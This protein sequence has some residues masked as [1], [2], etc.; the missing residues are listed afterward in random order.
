MRLNKTLLAAAALVSVTAATKAYDVYYSDWNYSQPSFSYGSYGVGN[1]W[2]G[3]E[4][5]TLNA[6]RTY[7][8]P[9]FGTVVNSNETILVN[10]GV[11]RGISG[12]FSWSGNEYDNNGGAPGS[13]AYVFGEL[14][15]GSETTVLGGLVPQ[16]YFDGGEGY[17][18]SGTFNFDSTDTTTNLAIGQV[19]YGIYMDTDGNY[20]GQNVSGGLTVYERNVQVARTGSGF[21]G[22]NAYTAFAFDNSETLSGSY[23][24]GTTFVGRNVL[25]TASAWSDGEGNYGPSLAGSVIR[26]GDI[27]L[28][29]SG[30]EGLYA[31]DGGWLDIRGDLTLGASG[32][33]YI[34]DGEI[35]ANTYTQYYAPGT[36]NTLG[37]LSIETGILSVRQ[38]FAQDMIA[39]WGQ[40]LGFRDGAVND[41]RL[42]LSGLGYGFNGEGFYGPLGSAGGALRSITGENVQ[43]GNISIFGD[44][45]GF[46][47]FVSGAVIGTDLGSKLTING[48]INGLD[49]LGSQGGSTLVFSSEGETVQNGHILSGIDDVIK[50]GQGELLIN[51]SNT[52]TGDLA[53]QEGTVRITNSGAL[54]GANVDPLVSDHTYVSSG[55]ALVL[56]QAAGLSLGD[57]IYITGTGTL[58]TGAALYNKSGSNATTG[59]V[60]VQNGDATVRVDASSSLTVGSVSAGST[61]Y[62]LTLDVRGAD[63]TAGNFTVNSQTYGL[64]NLVK[65][66]TGNATV[67]ELSGALGDIDVNGG[68]L[69]VLGTGSSALNVFDRLDIDGTLDGEGAPLGN[70]ELRGDYHYGEFNVSA[71]NTLIKGNVTHHGAGGY[72]LDISDNAVVTVDT[73]ATLTTEQNGDVDASA[74]IIDKSKLIVKGTFQANGGSIID[75]DDEATVEV[76][77]GGVVNSYIIANDDSNVVIRTGGTIVGNV[78]T[79]DNAQFTI[80]SGATHTGDYNAYGNADIVVNG[81]IGE[82]NALSTNFLLSGSARL[83]GSGRVSGD[84]QQIAGTVAPGNSTNILSVGGNYSIS[85]SGVL[86][87]EIGGTDGPANDPTGNDQLRVTGTVTVSGGALLDF[88]PYNGYLPVRRGVFQILATSAGAARATIGKF[89]TVDTTGLDNGAG[90]E[91]RMLFDHSTGK[92][93]GTG[94]VRGVQTFR[95]YGDSAN[96]RE[97]GR[98]LWMESIA[99][100]G[101]AFDDNYGTG[102]IN[103]SEAL[104]NSGLKTFIL[105]KDASLVD[106]TQ[107]ATDLGAAAVSVLSAV[108]VGAALD[109]LSP[110]AYSGFGEIAVRLNRNIAL[111]GANGRR[112]GDEKNWGFSLGYSG[113]QLTSSS[114]SGYTGYKVSSDTTYLNAD[115]AL[116]TK[117]HLNL[118][119]GLDDGR[120]TARGLSGDTNTAVFGL[121]LGFTP[122]SKFARLDIGGSLSIS[123]FSSVRQGSYVEQDSQ[124]AYAVAARLTFLP[125]DPSLKDV[126]EGKAPKL[127]LIPY[128]GVSYASADVDAITEQDS[129]GGVQLAV[130]AFKRRSLVG[131]LGMNAEYELGANTTLTGVFAYEHDFRNGGRTDMNA[132]FVEDGVTDTNFAIRTDGLGSSIFRLGVGIRQKLGAKASLGFGYDALLGSG[133]TSGQQVKA[134]LSFRF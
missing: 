129:V 68:K 88:K 47:P 10:A 54:S 91:V 62:V 114:G 8:F 83:S 106:A 99:K 41:T 76:Q 33:I 19:H 127:S 95:D 39:T 70:L 58:A 53:I 104:A 48:N 35:T 34:R 130:D 133:V 108:D 44:A 12:S 40:T 5:R 74:D 71:V 6:D 101:T 30:A 92:A 81:T 102:A 59:E 132:A 119:A 72:D 55:A 42:V 109:A 77:S 118:T 85:G 128:V 120:V 61:D 15:T 96:R 14:Q 82:S 56:D 49:S 52:F 22:A 45:E 94:L 7:G 32:T 4:F 63:A 17:Y 51:S 25:P 37:T 78:D 46:G 28:G 110:E 9:G 121:G 97:I 84:L 90:D 31:K 75:L 26:T 126:S 64:G 23:Y 113:E 115:L 21:N 80:E 65:N 98:A 43:N 24:N 11:Y 93:Y 38:H 16:N 36:Y 122:E 134:D 13:A 86:E 79:Y 125:K 29:F 27:G 18:T 69:L 20:F 67:T 66:G 131:E 117:V 107:V 1:G 3:T 103:P 60:Y 111:A 50:L 116:G 2:T 89:N 123:D 100:D 87:I 57:D 105:T 112:S 73:G 124:N